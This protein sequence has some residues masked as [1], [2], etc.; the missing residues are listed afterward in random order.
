MKEEGKLIRVH[1]VSRKSLF[2]PIG[3]ADGPRSAGELE[4]SRRTELK[5]TDT[6]QEEVL[7]DNWKTA[8]VPEANL[9]KAW[10]G[11]TIFQT[12]ED[13]EDEE[14]QDEEQERERRPRMRPAPKKPTAAEV[15]YHN[16]THAEY[17]PWCPHCVR[18][19]GV[20]DAHRSRAEGGDDRIPMLS[21]D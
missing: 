6:G 12:R 7:N 9:E 8:E 19:R 5:Y 18:G 15:E 4:G 17:R 13:L 3:A 11:R 14:M 10:T 2:T 21:M 1:V 20:R 16:L